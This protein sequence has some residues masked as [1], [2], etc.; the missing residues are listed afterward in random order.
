MVGV[1]AD[2]CLG[3]LKRSVVVMLFAKEEAMI[4]VATQVIA[5]DQGQQVNHLMNLC[6]AHPGNEFT[7]EAIVAELLEKG[8]KRLFVCSAI[9]SEEHR[10][11]VGGRLSCE[12]FPPDLAVAGSVKFAEK[13]ALPGTQVQEA[14]VEKNGDR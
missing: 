2:G 12:N 8:D 14:L 1:A 11:S 6:F 7:G 5:H 10:L 13:N 9:E 4:F 3:L